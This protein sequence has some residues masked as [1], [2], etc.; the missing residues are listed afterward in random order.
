MPIDPSKNKQESTTD[1]GRAID[2]HPHILGSPP[3]V[4]SVEGSNPQPT[5]PLRWLHHELS[6]L[7]CL[8]M[9]KPRASKDQGPLKQDSSS[10][11][12]KDIL[13][14]NNHIQIYQLMGAM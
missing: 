9:G 8:D 2:P 11:L 12:T 7:R 1:L 6:H 4:Y 10:Y 14:T 3:L 13:P 5:F